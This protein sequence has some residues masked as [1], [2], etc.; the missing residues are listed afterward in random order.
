MIAGNMKVIFFV[1]TL[2]FITQ[3]IKISTKFIC[4]CDN[5]FNVLNGLSPTLDVPKFL[6]T[7]I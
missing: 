7:L 3:Y 5:L 4:V 6:A 1:H 2:S